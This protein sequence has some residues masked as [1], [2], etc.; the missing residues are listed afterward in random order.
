MEF[1]E[2]I[3]CSNCS[4]I[5]WL[6]ASNEI[7]IYEWWA[8][9]NDKWENAESVKFLSI[10][11]Y[12]EALDN[13]VFSTS[14]EEKYIRLSIH[15]AFND[16]VRNGEIMFASDS[17]KT[18]WSDNAYRLLDLLNIGDIQEK[19]L[20]AELNRNLGQFEKCQTILSTI[21]DLDYS[22]LKIAFEKACNERNINVFQL[23]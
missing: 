13:K 18:Q 16:R 2:L 4:T 20:I 22:R 21:A 1:P 19:I 9:K 17:D 10:Y 12:L 14:S 7:A 6:K 15:R 8:S 11:E 3:I 23:N 5:F